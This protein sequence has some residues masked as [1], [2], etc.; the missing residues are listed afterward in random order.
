[1]LDPKDCNHADE[2]VEFRGGGRVGVAWTES[3]A[4]CPDCGRTSKW[5]KEAG[6]EVSYDADDASSKKDALRSTGRNVKKYQD[7]KNKDSK[8]KTSWWKK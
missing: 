1:V 6:T 4:V 2:A 5:A 7:K 3:R 8:G